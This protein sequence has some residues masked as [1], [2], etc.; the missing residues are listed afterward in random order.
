MDRSEP[1]FGLT[2]IGGRADF[3][4]PQP[5]LFALGTP[6]QTFLEFDLFDPSLATAE[7]LATVQDL[8]AGVKTG[9]G[10][11]VVVGFRPTLW[12]TVR[13]DA[14]PDGLH[15][16]EAAIEYLTLWEPGVRA[17]QRRGWCG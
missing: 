2:R 5:G 7:V 11:N 16:F 9:Q 4:L 14:C 6:V 12:R 13:P 10:C 1:T 15:D 8:V 17:G 3:V